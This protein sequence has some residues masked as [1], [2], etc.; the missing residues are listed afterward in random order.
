MGPADV[1]PW[2]EE[3]VGSAKAKCCNAVGT[4]F[5]WPGK[6]ENPFLSLFSA[7]SLAVRTGIPGEGK[8]K[9]GKGKRDQGPHRSSQVSVPSRASVRAGKFRYLDIVGVLVVCLLS[10]SA[11]STGNRCMGRV[12][13]SQSPSLPSPLSPARASSSNYCTVLPR[14]MLQAWCG[15]PILPGLAGSG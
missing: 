10:P 3:G 8:G 6:C 11:D 14:Y 15:Q 7:P 12:T 1:I 13:V 2:R 5:G 9:R 4:N